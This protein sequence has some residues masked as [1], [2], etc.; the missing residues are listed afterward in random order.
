MV[1]VGVPVLEN[2]SGI[3]GGGSQ[4]L[5]GGATEIEEEPISME[6]PSGFCRVPV[7]EGNLLGGSQ[8]LRG[9]QK[10]FWGLGRWGGY[11]GVPP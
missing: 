5:G 10:W 2:N 7:L 11:G 4:V 6:D 8:V 9:A 1:F 3:L